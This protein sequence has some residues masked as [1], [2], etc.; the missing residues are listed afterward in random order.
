MKGHPSEAALSRLCSYLYMHVYI[1]I[2]SERARERLVRRVGIPMLEVAIPISL[3]SASGHLCRSLYLAIYLS[4]HGLIYTHMCIC[5]GRE[6]KSENGEKGGHA[7]L[8]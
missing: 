5:I 3:E 8:F 1:H 2:E 7:H 6:S 4:L